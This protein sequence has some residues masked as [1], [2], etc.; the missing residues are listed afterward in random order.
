MLLVVTTVD[1]RFKDPNFLD[2]EPAASICDKLLQMMLG[3]FTP[4][5]AQPGEAQDNAIE[6]EQQRG[7]PKDEAR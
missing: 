6:M 1:P 3:N 4:I 7:L 5:V 2:D